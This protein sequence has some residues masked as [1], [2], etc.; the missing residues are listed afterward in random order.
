LWIGHIAF[1]LIL[2]CPEGVT[3]GAIRVTF[4][5]A[6]AMAVTAGVGA[7]FGLLA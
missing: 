7:L 6:L 5:G 2:R 4:W 1:R 3:V